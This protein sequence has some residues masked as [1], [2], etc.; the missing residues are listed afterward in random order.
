MKVLQRNS[1]A[2]K[3]WAVVVDAL[4]GGDQILILR[5]GGIHEGTGGFEVE[6]REFFLFPTYEHQNQEELI[7]SVHA[8]LDALLQSRPQD[9]NIHLQFYA[10]VQAV[11]QAKELEK[12]YLL[13]GQHVWSRSVVEERFSWGR[14]KGLYVLCLRIFR[15]PEEILVPHRSEYEGCKSWVNL[16]ENFSTEGA[17]VLSGKEFH[18]K[19]HVVQ[20]IFQE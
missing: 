15:L 7:P 13:E 20:K 9:G 19:L 12:L 10:S 3:E 16:G 17:P 2:F 1:K 8:R 5:K 18:Q 14:E 4:G 11:Y 6:E